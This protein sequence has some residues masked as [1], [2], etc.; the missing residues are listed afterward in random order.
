MA[1]ASDLITTFIAKKRG[2]RHDLRQL[3]SEFFATCREVNEGERRRREARDQTLRGTSNVDSP[4]AVD[5][6]TA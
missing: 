3:Q 1:T 2:G 6:A 4:V 5:K